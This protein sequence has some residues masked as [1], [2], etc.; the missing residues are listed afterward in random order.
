MKAMPAWVV[1]AALLLGAAPFVSA[2]THQ[3][4]SGSIALESR[5]FSQSPLDSGQRGDVSVSIAFQPEYYLEWDG[6]DQSFTFVPFVR[7]DQHDN[8]RTHWDIRELFWLRAWEDWEL[9]AGIRK[10]FWGVTESQHLVDIIN[11]TD[12]V[13]N[14]DGEDKL[15]QPM[16]KAS[17][18]QDWGTVEAYWMPFFRERTFPGS[19]RRQKPRLGF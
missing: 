8:E 19:T 18:I 9:S 3:D 1:S 12:L 13:E 16:I 7:W 11:Q 4:F 6:R 14:L 5:F 17:W 15:G 10:V 2:E